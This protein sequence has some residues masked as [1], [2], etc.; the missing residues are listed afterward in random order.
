MGPYCFIFLIVNYRILIIDL[1][2]LKKNK[3]VQNHKSNSISGNVHPITRRI[4]CIQT[5]RPN[6]TLQYG[7]DKKSQCRGQ[8]RQSACIVGRVGFWGEWCVDGGLPG[9]NLRLTTSSSSPPSERLRRRRPSR[10]GGYRL[11][12]HWRILGHI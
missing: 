12:S 7:V 9:D 1:K 8:L 6:H 10:T 2:R 4:P 11:Q 5:H 3:I